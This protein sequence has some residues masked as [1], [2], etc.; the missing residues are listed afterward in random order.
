MMGNGHILHTLLPGVD[1]MTDYWTDTTENITFSQLHWQVV[2][3]M[4][5]VFHC[6]VSNSI[7]HVSSLTW[8][9]LFYADT[10]ISKVS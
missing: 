1:R 2:T 6:D 3:T 7:V 8:N 5:H 4:G 9:E 10:S